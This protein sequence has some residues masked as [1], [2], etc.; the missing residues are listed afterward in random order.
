MHVTHK[1]QEKHC[2]W[3]EVIYGL[4]FRMISLCH[5]R[6]LAVRWWTPGSA[7]LSDKAS[8]SPQS[9]RSSLVCPLCIQAA[10]LRWPKHQRHPPPGQ[11][12]DNYQGSV[13]V[14][15]MFCWAG[16]GTWVATSKYSHM[17]FY[18]ICLA[19]RWSL[20]YT[21]P[22][23]VCPISLAKVQWS[24]ASALVKRTLISH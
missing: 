2:E 24:D 11:T 20:R 14:W 8:P 22:D 15:L 4:Q 19:D 5:P 3:E 18:S 16:Q 21:L 12:A 6:R 1:E 23:P 9:A 10:H 17:D 13:S 7:W